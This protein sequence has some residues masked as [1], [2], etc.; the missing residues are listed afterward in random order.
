MVKAGMRPAA[1]PGSCR[2]RETD[3]GG[4]RNGLT[5]SGSQEAHSEA[6]GSCRT[7]TGPNCLR[8]SSSAVLAQEKMAIFVLLGPQ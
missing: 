7:R 6:A 8:T 4:T 3:E 2:C 5:R 1:G